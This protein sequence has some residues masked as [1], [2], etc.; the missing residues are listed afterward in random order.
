MDE[1]S[2]GMY[3]VMLM[4]NEDFKDNKKLQLIF[5]KVYENICARAVSR[6]SRRMLPSKV[7]TELS[8]KQ[9]AVI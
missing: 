5:R 8:S 9:F 7:S 3:T 1:G 6:L 4:W 2:R